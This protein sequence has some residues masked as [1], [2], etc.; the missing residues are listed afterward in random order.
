MP[1]ALGKSHFSRA[2]W[3]TLVTSSVTPRGILGMPWGQP[4]GLALPQTTG[5]AVHPD[6]C[7]PSHLVG[8]VS[9][10]LLCSV[11]PCWETGEQRRTAGTWHPRSALFHKYDLPEQVARAGLSQEGQEEQE[12]QGT[13]SQL[14]P[15]LGLM[16]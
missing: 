1:R 2:A 8:Q 6:F 13:T 14:A 10:H 4:W 5:F 15:A 11:W 7:L 16:K 9:T 3:R 12:E